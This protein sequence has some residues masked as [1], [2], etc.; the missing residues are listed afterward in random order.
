MKYAIELKDVL[1]DYGDF[2][3]DN[4]SFVVP[5][6]CICGF[7]GQ[8]GAGKTTTIKL[9]LDIIKKDGGEIKVFDQNVDSLSELK[10]EDKMS[11]D[12]VVEATGSTGGFEVSASLVKPRGTLVLKSTI[13][14]K[15]GLNL[16]T[17]VVNEITIVGSRCGQ[18]K[19]I[20]K[21]LALNG[22]EC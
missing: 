13:A 11:F 15:E 4:I 10:D 22:F 7:I 20:I 12:V 21:L 16:A 17:I 14:A 5:E 19:P 8:N 18:F 2:K 1:K 9:I 3:L 6:G